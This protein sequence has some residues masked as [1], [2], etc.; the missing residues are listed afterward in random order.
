MEK[1]S[2][3]HKHM[4]IKAH[5]GK[6]PKQPAKANKM[7]LGLVAAIGMVPVTKPQSVYISVPGNEGLTG[8]VNL[9][10]SHIAYHIWD[11][12]GLL[13]MDVYSCCEFDEMV[14]LSYLEDYFKF[15]VVEYA[16]IDRNNLGKVLIHMKMGEV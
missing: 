15:N 9:A 7:L 5:V 6:F 14:V 3:I 1:F 8:S 13:M 12:S 2:P 10:T 16:T 11:E 4:L